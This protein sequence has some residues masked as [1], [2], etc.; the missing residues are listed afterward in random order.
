[1]NV[2]DVLTRAGVDPEF[3]ELGVIRIARGP[4]SDSAADPVGSTLA[5]ANYADDSVS[6]I[7]ASSRTVDADVLV[8]GEPLAVAVADNRVYVATTSASY[9]SVAVIDTDTR[10]VVAVCLLKYGIT[11]IAVDPDGKRV[12][13]GTGR[14]AADLA[15]IDVTAEKVSTIEL[16]SAAGGVV[17]AV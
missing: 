9:D 11:G 2:T 16:A 13:V 12:Y 7:D 4:I 5:V 15:V 3:A 8:D 6:L 10:A 17:D 14:D 1:M